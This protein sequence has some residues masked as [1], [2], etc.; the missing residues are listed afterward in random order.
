MQAT[1]QKVASALRQRFSCASVKSGQTPTKS[2]CKRPISTVSQ[3]VACAVASPRA[4]KT[5]SALTFSRRRPVAA[6]LFSSNVCQSSDRELFL[7]P[8]GADCGQHKQNESR[9]QLHCQ[10]SVDTVATAQLQ[11][12]SGR[13]AQDRCHCAFNSVSNRFIGRTS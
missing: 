12:C 6:R 13:F 1:C 2:G 7:Q 10:S 8:H 3:S 11:F 4:T 9:S 5:S